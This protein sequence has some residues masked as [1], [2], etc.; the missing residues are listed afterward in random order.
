MERKHEAAEALRIHR[1]KE[2]TSEIM[3]REEEI[4]T[5][6]GDLDDLKVK[7]EK[8]KQKATDE[9]NA[10]KTIIRQ[11]KDDEMKRLNDDMKK[12]MDIEAEK[13]GM[14]GQIEQERLEMKEKWDT[15]TLNIKEQKQRL[16]ELKNDYENNYNILQTE[17]YETKLDKEQFELEKVQALRRIHESE[18]DLRQL[19]AERERNVKAAESHVMLKRDILELKFEEKRVELDIEKSKLSYKVVEQES[20]MCQAAESLANAQQ[21]LEQ[22]TNDENLKI[23]SA[24][25]KFSVMQKRLAETARKAEEELESKR[26][27]YDQLSE[28]RRETINKERDIVSNM[29]LDL[30]ALTLRLNTTN[31]LEKTTIEK[32]IKTKRQRLNEQETQLKLLEIENKNISNDIEE[33]FESELNRIQSKAQEDQTALELERLHLEELQDSK[34][35]KLHKEE[36]ELHEEQKK[37]NEMKKMLNETIKALNNIEQQAVET[38]TRNEKDVIEICKHLE[39]QISGTEQHGEINKLREHRVNLKEIDVEGKLQL[40]EE[41]EKNGITRQQVHNDIKRLSYELEERSRA[42]EKLEKELK[43]LKEK[44]G[45]ERMEESATLVAMHESIQDME[46]EA[47]LGRSLTENE[48][49]HKAPINKLLEKEKIK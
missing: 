26:R 3:Q 9:V 35:H 8:I 33:E 40:A 34:T 28:H 27:Q 14:R 22:R 30:D 24:K 21:R 15:A 7:S 18:D 29:R 46:E 5:V 23:N 12:I 1:E 47:S 42:K 44:Y 31:E 10:L 6:R 48:I 32:E 2:L 13:N 37:Y 19:Y 4:K 20:K 38:S 25:E 36:R 41:N 39:D 43:E 17:K 11:Q 16:G 49:T 45:R